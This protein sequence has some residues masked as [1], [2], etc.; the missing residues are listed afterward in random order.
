MGIE[1]RLRA[2]AALP[3][4]TELV[5]HYG[6]GLDAIDQLI[7]NAVGNYGFY[8]QIAAEKGLRQ[9][10]A[11]VLSVFACTAGVTLSDLLGSGPAAPYSR[12]GT[13]PAGQLVEAGWELW[14]TDVRVDG[15]TVEFSHVH[16]DV[17]LPSG[18]LE[19]PTDLAAMPRTARRQLR[20]AL[21]PRFSALLE[22]FE[23]R[24]ER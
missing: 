12:Y 20:E 1:V 9:P 6:A 22:L 19:I 16:F 11:L 5:V 24:R 15:A 21:R 2:A 8:E 18:D 3:E 14:P 4:R 17:W 13:V 23:P 10:G 7:T